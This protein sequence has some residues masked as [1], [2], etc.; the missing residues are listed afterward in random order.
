MACYDENRLEIAKR[1]LDPNEGVIC[2]QCDKNEDAYLK[3][4]M[5]EVFVRD[6]FVNSISVQSSTPSGLKLAHR[7]NHYQ[8]K[9]YSF[10]L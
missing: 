3:V 7:K 1:L 2:I 8:D 5:D 9:R 4:L 6:N 10:N